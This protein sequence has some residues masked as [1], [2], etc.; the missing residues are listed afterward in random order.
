MFKSKLFQTSNV[1]PHF[2]K[3]LLNILNKNVQAP[4]PRDRIEWGPVPEKKQ[5][6]RRSLAS[7]ASNAGNSKKH[8]PF[9]KWH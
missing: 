2:N 4:K 5:R 9:A 7:L 1:C 8:D 3:T 6:E